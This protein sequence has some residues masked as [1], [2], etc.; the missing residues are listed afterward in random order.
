MFATPAQPETKTAH[1]EEAT[2]KAPQFDMSQLKRY[3]TEERCKAD[4]EIVQ[5]ILKSQGPR[6][7]LPRLTEEQ[8][9]SFKRDGWVFVPSEQI[10]SDEQ[11]YQL[12]HQ[13]NVMDSWP[14]MAHHWMKYFEK[15]RNKGKA[16]HE[17]E[18]EKI[19]QRIENFLEYNPS[20]NN[21]INDERMLGFVGQLFGEDAVLYKEKINYKLPGGDGFNPH[22]DVAA[23]WWMY[24]QSLHISVLIG[25]DAASPENG[26]L[27]LVRGAHRDGMLSPEWKE[28][29][30]EVCDR[31]TWEMAATRP[32]DVVFFD[33]YVPH[34][35]GPNYTDKPRR[36]AYTTYAKKAEGDFRARYYS[37]KRK[38]FPPDIEREQGKSYEYKI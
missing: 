3:E 12:I 14:E 10:W 38:S 33:S 11:L 13:V 19:L 8:V 31:L 21:L 36:V 6:N 20:L 35:S 26:A 15:N 24:G 37:D 4:E 17:D 7:P 2:S 23:G 22:Q 29:P 25:I 9:A 18:P 5:G 34:R 32:G 28:L 1:T 27:E 30:K 16:G